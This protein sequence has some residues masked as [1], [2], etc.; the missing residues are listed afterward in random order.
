MDASLRRKTILEIL[1]GTGS[2]VSATSL[3]AQLGVSRQVIVGDV[4]L[5]RAAGENISATPRG[6]VLG[7]NPGGLRRTVACIHNL[8]NLE[9][10]LLIMVDN[11]CTVLD[12]VIEHPVYGQLTGEL[13]LSSRFDVRQF[14]ERL[15]SEGAPPLS[16]LTGGIHLHNL[17]C[18]D[19][20]AFSRTCA[21]LAEAR[22]LLPEND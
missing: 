18:P 14:T 21:A 9:K 10:E 7:G 4:A 2:P 15:M 22:F 17:L 1:T 13:C 19:E 16:A 6:Y 12:V 5:L 8:D 20:A 11:G 3:A